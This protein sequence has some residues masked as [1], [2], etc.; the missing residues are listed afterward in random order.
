M[1]WNFN[2]GYGQAAITG[3]NPNPVGKVFFVGDQSTANIDMIKQIFQP[4]PDGEI[5]YTATIDAANNLCTA[6]AGDLIL[7]A[8]G[9]TETLT[10]TDITLD[11]AGVTVLGLGS[12]SLRPTLSMN[13]ALAEVSSV[14]ASM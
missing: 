6:N 5:R 7:V 14:S 2:S 10:A 3:L 13:N 4:D 9:H 12:G 11:I 8:P 1:T